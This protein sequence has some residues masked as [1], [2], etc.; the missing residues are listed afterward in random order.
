MMNVFRICLAGLLLITSNLTMA[1]FESL[2]FISPTNAEKRHIRLIDSLDFN[3]SKLDLFKSTYKTD[4]AIRV[5]D[6]TKTYV[7][8]FSDTVN[9]DRSSRRWIYDFVVNS[10]S[11]YNFGSTN[12]HYKSR[13]GRHVAEAITALE[14]L[15]QFKIRDKWFVPVIADSISPASN[16]KNQHQTYYDHFEPLFYGKT[17]LVLTNHRGHYGYDHVGLINFSNTIC[18]YFEVVE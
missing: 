1:Q 4:S 13:T 18:H 10:D 5:F 11:I 7:H 9:Y 6:T 8:R 15:D 17:V 3:K 16:Q 12:F 2:G 14:L